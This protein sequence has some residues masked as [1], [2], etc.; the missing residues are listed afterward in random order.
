MLWNGWAFLSLPRCPHCWSTWVCI[1]MPGKSLFFTKQC[2]RKK[3]NFPFFSFLF[4]KFQTNLQEKKK[5]WG[6]NQWFFY[7][8]YWVLLAQREHQENSSKKAHVNLSF[9][10]VTTLYL[11]PFVFK[12][13]TRFSSLLVVEPNQ[14][15]F[16][17]L[18]CFTLPSLFLSLVFIHDSLL[19]R[20]S[21][22]LVLTIWTWWDTWIY[23]LE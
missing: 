22:Y 20:H 14:K 11:S 15:V 10:C 18:K 5:E 1:F 17:F 9:L 23:M 7:V 2:K 16:F 13:E 8:W 6:E 12:H 3:N 4:L 21:C 19:F